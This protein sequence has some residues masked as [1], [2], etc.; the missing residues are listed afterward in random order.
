MFSLSTD[1]FSALKINV[2]KQEESFESF[3]L[4]CQ[5]DTNTAADATSSLEISLNLFFLT[6]SA[7]TRCVSR[8]VQRL[9]VP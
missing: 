4:Q 9:S 6:F 3:Y 8:K 2:G 7:Q 5:T 1:K